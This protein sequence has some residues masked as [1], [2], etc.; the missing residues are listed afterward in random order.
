MKEIYIKRVMESDDAEDLIGTN[1]GTQDPNLSEEAIYRDQDT[2]EVV[3][4]YCKN[5]GDTKALRE[6]VLGMKYSVTTRASGMQNISRTFGFSPK[7]VVMKREYCKS[8]GLSYESPE[9]Q[10][11]LNQTA[12][13]LAKLLKEVLPELHEEDKKVLDGNILPEWQMTEDSLWTSGVINKASQLP[14]HRDRNNFETWSAMPVVRRG[15][16]GGHLHLPEYGITINCRDGYTLYFNGFR[17][18]HGVT[19]MKPRTKDAYRYSIVFYALR[20][21]KDCHTYAVEVANG[22]KSRIERENKEAD[23]IEQLNREQNG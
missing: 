19:P 8:S 16:D 13:A 22:Y 18:V 6:T 21:M 20:G 15:M 17:F 3:L 4:F 12:D 10:I 14:Y 7:N 2:G 1:V 5:P 9:S 11:V 23:K